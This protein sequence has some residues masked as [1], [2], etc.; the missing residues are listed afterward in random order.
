MGCAGQ[1]SQ[2]HEEST[3]QP[4][5][6]VLAS[7]APSACFGGT[8][9]TQ[10]TLGLMSWLIV[11]QVKDNRNAHSAPNPNFFFFQQVEKEMYITEEKK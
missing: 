2:T 9:G 3:L 7:Y 4:T 8:W 5:A 10:T 1:K 6:Q 11:V